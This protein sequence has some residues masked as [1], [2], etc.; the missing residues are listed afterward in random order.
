LIEVLAARFEC[1]EDRIR[2][3]LAADLKDA[4]GPTT[5]ETPQELDEGEWNAFITPRQE[6]SENDRFITRHVSLVEATS[7]AGRSKALLLLA[8]LID[9]VVLAVKLREVRALTGFTRY[10]P[11]GTVV[12]PDLS[13]GIDWLPAIE[14][15]GEGLFVSLSESALQRWETSEEAVALA[16]ELEQRRKQSLFG[17]RLP[18]ATPRFL[19]LHTFAHLVV[20]ELAFQ[21]GY[22]SSSLRERIYAKTPEQ[23]PPQAGFLV[24]TAA[25]DVE[26]TLG[27]LARQGEAPRLAMAILGGL[28]RA[29]W[30][31]ADPICRESRGQ[32]FG[33]LNLG[34]CHSCTLLSETSCEYGNTLLHRGFAVGGV[35]SAGM[36]GFFDDVLEAA[37]K[38]A[39]TARQP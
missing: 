13:R 23:G 26:G 36:P 25:G 3:V 27:G 7:S 24:Y 20:R 17:A 39:L 28:D 1:S 14:V 15:F 29:S 30:C 37:R 19:L 5:S 8:D 11:E 9:R 38:E 10:D 6:E 2:A 21:C 16:A 35:R 22:S 31:S 12:Q 18:R 4:V 33:S 34:A 32:G